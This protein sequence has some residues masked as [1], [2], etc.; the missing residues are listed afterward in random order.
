VNISNKRTDAKQIKAATFEYELLTLNHP[1]FSNISYLLHESEN[2][3]TQRKGKSE[4]HRTAL[5]YVQLTD[6]IFT[7]LMISQ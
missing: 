3:E 4:V 1:D 6:I 2:S 7:V 5:L